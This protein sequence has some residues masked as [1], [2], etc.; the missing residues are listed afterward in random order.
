MTRIIA[1][2]AGL[3]FAPLA[4][5]DSALTDENFG[6]VGGI[7]HLE[8]QAFEGVALVEAAGGRGGE[9]GGEHLPDPR[10]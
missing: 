10:A 8:S 6:G 5:S 9:T 2:L 1:L 7:Y 3:F 4:Q